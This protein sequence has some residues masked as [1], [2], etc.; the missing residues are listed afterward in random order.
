[1]SP[2]C[3][4]QRLR[5]AVAKDAGPY[6]M[7]SCLFMAALAASCLQSDLATL[8]LVPAALSSSLLA[9]GLLSRLPI[10]VAVPIRV[11]RRGTSRPP[12]P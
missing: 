2:R 7:F 5:Q 11:A 3:H 12:R 10:L 6:T 1:M 4:V 9:I 8:A